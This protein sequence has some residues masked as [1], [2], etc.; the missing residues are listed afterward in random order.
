M[1]RRLLALALASALATPAMAQQPPAPTPAVAPTRCGG[2]LCDVYY[3]GK[4]QPAPGQ[5]DIATPFDSLPCHDFLCRMFGGRAEVA[6]PVQQAA[7]EPAPSD[8]MTTPKAPH[9]GHH[10]KHAAKMARAEAKAAR[11]DAKAGEASVQ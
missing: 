5:P 6:P 7:V 10:R 11:P 9:H 8:A 1:S 3:A 2:L 4:P